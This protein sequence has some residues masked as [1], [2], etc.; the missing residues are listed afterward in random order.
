MFFDMGWIENLGKEIG[1]FD[2]YKWGSSIYPHQIPVAKAIAQGSLIIGDEMGLGKTLEC[3][4][5]LDLAGSKRVLVI[6]PAG[7]VKNF[8]REVKQWTNRPVVPMYGMN[9]G[10]K[11]AIISMLQRMDN[12]V[13][14]LNYESWRKDDELL[15]LLQSLFFDAVVCDEAHC[16]K[17]SS[18][19]VAR[20]VKKLVLGENLPTIEGWKPSCSRVVLMTGTPIL[21]IP[22]DI[23]TML[24][25]VDPVKFPGES[26][27]IQRYCENNWANKQVWAPGGL[28][29]LKYDISGMFVA[30]DKKAAGI[31]LPPQREVIHELVLDPEK[32]P[33]QYKYYKMLSKYSQI[34]L[35][36]GK[37]LTA[38]AIISLILRKRQMATW[39]GGIVQKDKE[40]N[41]VFSVAEDCKESVKVDAA[42][43]IIDGSGK[44][45]V[46]FSQFTTPLTELG[47]R[48]SKRGYRVATYDGKTSKEDRAK[49]EKEFDRRTTEGKIDVVLC[50]YSTGGVGLNLTAATQVVLLDEAWNPGKRDQ[51]YARVARIG[52][53]QETTIHVLRVTETI[54]TWMAGIIQ[55]KEGVV[56]DFDSGVED[57]NEALMEAIK[58]G[59]I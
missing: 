38:L 24:H 18:S 48:L 36:D 2:K 41:T 52:Q 17:D 50:N 16:L 54:D 45:T 12:F 14:I 22:S 55:L 31:I 21:N 35:E 3:L 8:E 34:L 23:Y 47:S 11:R 27:F 33:Q 30:R 9:Q 15:T 29:R 10:E 7:V 57:L 53:T 5:G 39:P 59:D 43:E 56:G 44:K 20:G 28:H 13:V 51:A 40:G 25:L 42:T 58:A 1:E 37:T 26:N 46:V 49:V 4:A 19:I 32:Y 6:T